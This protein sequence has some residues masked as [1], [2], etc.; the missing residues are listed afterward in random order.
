MPLL[1]EEFPMSLDWFAPAQCVG[2]IAFVL[3]VA[4]AMQKDDRRFKLFM[5]G[6]CLAY[7]VHFALLGN[8]TPV[9]APST[10][11]RAW[12]ASRR[13]WA[14]WRA[15]RSKPRNATIIRTGAMSNAC[16]KSG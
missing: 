15:S 6:E 16:S 10:V 1:P 5:A 11:Q 9:A 13:P 3:G 7:I 2:Y 12:P 4:C 8:M 14:S